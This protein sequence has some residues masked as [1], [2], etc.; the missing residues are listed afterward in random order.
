MKYTK[1]TVIVDG[2]NLAPVKY[3]GSSVSKDTDIRL[4]KSLAKWLL[5]NDDFEIELF[6]DSGDFRPGNFKNIYIHVSKD[7]EDADN[8]IVKEVQNC[9]KCGQNCV[10]ITNDNYLQKRVVA[11][12][13]QYI[14]C[15]IFVNGRSG[16]EEY[17]PLKL[18]FPEKT[19]RPIR[20]PKLNKRSREDHKFAVTIDHV[21]VE[22]DEIINIGTLTAE[23]ETTSDDAVQVQTFG[24]T[25]I[26]VEKE[27][28]LPAPRTPRKTMIKISINNW[29]I[30][31]GMAFLI[32]S[33]CTRHKPQLRSLSL[34][35]HLAT[36]DDLIAVYKLFLQ[37]CKTEEGLIKRGGCLMDDVKLILIRNYPNPMEYQTLEKSLGYKSGLRNKIQRNN[38]KWVELFEV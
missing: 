33:A 19:F 36:R 9:I 31:E 7:G 6:F 27:Y 4:L 23:N 20:I 38:G 18:L 15:E 30:K 16:D 13:Q 37:M 14:S 12:G 2:N 10:V 1:F 26:I 29:P 5:K 25:D 32:N 8:D 24:K 21:P 28:I 11:L 22:Q 17:L 34:N 35:N 3:P